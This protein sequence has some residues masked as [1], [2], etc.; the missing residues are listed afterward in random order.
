MRIIFLL[1][2]FLFAPALSFACDQDGSSKLG[3]FQP[4]NQTAENISPGDTVISIDTSFIP[5][6][7]KD[8]SPEVFNAN[9]Y[10]L[11]YLVSRGNDQALLAGL[12]ALAYILKHPTYTIECDHKVELYNKNE[13]AHTLSR[14]LNFSTVSCKLPADERER[15]YSFYKSN[16]HLF[17]S[18]FD[19]PWE[20]DACESRSP[21]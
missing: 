11:Y 8:P 4:G 7:L 13:I 19:A 2:C 20:Y 9:R 16:P 12:K 21:G 3:Y 14:S 6:L 10:E 5:A 18:M 15:V 17:Q 1:S